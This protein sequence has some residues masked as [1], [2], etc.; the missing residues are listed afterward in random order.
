MLFVS[1][2]LTLP[3]ILPLID[4]LLLWKVDRLSDAAVLAASLF[5]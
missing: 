4:V 2:A 5:V 1:E 3:D